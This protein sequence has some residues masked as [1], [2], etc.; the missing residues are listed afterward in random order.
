MGDFMY[1]NRSQPYGYTP[2]LMV[3]T[4]IWGLENGID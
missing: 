1:K 3:I 2:L 4:R